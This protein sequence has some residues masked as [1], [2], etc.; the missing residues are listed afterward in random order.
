MNY[1]AHL[2]LA[3]EAPESLIGSLLGDFYKGRISDELAPALRAGV[4]LHRRVDAYT[5]AHPVVGRSKRRID[6]AFRRYAGILIDLFYD[7]FLARHW[8]R[9][10]AVPLEAFTQRVYG[11]LRARLPEL[12][13]PMQRS[14]G[15]LLANDLLMSYRRIDGIERA[16]CGIESRLKRPSRLGAAVVELEANYPDLAA[17]FDHFFPQ[18]MAF[19]ARQGEASA[20]PD[21]GSA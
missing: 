5:D 7:H 10:S 21:L 18:L 19:T 14:M 1:L 8:G 9:Y 12:P 17:D 13:P 4:V 16:L 2:Y 15:Y 3:D 6:P 11:V 20:V